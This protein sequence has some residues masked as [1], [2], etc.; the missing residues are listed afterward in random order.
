MNW[1]QKNELLTALSNLKTLQTLNIIDTNVQEMK[2]CCD[3]CATACQVQKDKGLF[4][5]FANRTYLFHDPYRLVN[6][7]EKNCLTDKD[8]FKFRI[9]DR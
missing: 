8:M 4:T 3:G 7:I 9:F 5:L 2:Y 1:K 6:Y